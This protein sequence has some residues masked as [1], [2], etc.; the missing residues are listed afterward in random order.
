VVDGKHGPALAV[1][2][3]LAE[4][5]RALRVLLE[6]KHVHYYLLKEGELFLADSQEDRIARGVYLLL[7]ELAAQPE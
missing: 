4:P 2:V 1:N 3:P 5:Q 6:G 7:A